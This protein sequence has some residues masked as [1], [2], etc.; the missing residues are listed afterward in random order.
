MNQEQVRYIEEDKIDLRELWQVLTKRKTTLLVVTGI[1]T[2]LAIVYVLVTKPTYAVKSVIE[3]AQINNK[4]IHNTYDIKQKLDFTY[5]VGL[6]GKKLELP[7][8]ESISIPK[9][10]ESLLVVKAHGYDNESATNKIKELITTL[11][12][13]Q[14]SEITNYVSLQTNRIIL[15]QEDINTT[16]QSIQNMIDKVALYENRLFDIEKKDA[17]LAGIYAIE[18][19]K[20]QAEINIMRKNR[21]ALNAEKNEL[22]F[23]ISPTN[24]TSTKIVGKIEVLDKPIK[25]KKTLIV[26]VAFITG[27]ML[28]IFLVFFLEFIQGSKREEL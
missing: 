18:L 2:A 11:K 24:I 20:M 22:I 19:G 21:S 7:I 8:I 10:T 4:N 5:E 1:I 16:E 15:I 27:L 9:K 13:L 25:P 12:A 17:A 14:N 28:S 23:S 26:V 6:K 3:L